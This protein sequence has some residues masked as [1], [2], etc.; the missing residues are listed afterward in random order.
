VRVHSIVCNLCVRELVALSPEVLKSR[1]ATPAAV[2]HHLRSSH[3]LCRACLALHGITDEHRH[4]CPVFARGFH[5]H[6]FGWSSGLS[7]AVRLDLRTQSP[8][9]LE[10][11]ARV[12]QTEVTNSGRAVSLET[13]ALV[14]GSAA[15]SLEAIVPVPTSGRIDGIARLAER[16]G[17]LLDLP[18]VAAV[19][20]KKHKS[21]RASGAR[22]RRQIAASEYQ[23]TPAS[24]AIQDRSVLLLDDMV[25]TG[26]TIAA[27]G[28]LLLE[29][30]ARAVQ[31]I[32][33]DR[34][35]SQRVLQ[36]ADNR[37]ADHCPHRSG[38]VATRQRALS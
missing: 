10:I 20:R 4:G 13:G 37:A 30:G 16:M 14:E 34:L 8:R 18:V 27:I 19:S 35:V 32:A 6:A 17:K 11:V 3:A 21:T 25:A 29:S 36:R 5:L 2:P 12:M 24:R 1:I 23:L 22:R 38:G 31:P 26:H 15:V 33:L 9:F 28:Q 7:E